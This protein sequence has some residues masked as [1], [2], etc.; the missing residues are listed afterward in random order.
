MG[1][2]RTSPATLHRRRQEG[3]ERS[4]TGD[5]MADLVRRRQTWSPDGLGT[6]S[7]GMLRDHLRQ[8]R[9]ASMPSR[10]TISRLLNRQ[11][12]EVPS[13]AFPSSGSGGLSH[14]CSG[15]MS[16]GRESAAPARVAWRWRREVEAPKN[17][18]RPRWAV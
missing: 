8:H 3:R 12:Q 13:H 4:L 11:T 6:V 2:T 5:P 1:E 16:T 9:V 14:L 15:N 17:A 10:R 7:A 18:A